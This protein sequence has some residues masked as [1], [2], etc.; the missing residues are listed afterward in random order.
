MDETVNYITGETREQLY[1]Y[2]I[3]S[4]NRTITDYIKQNREAE[5]ITWTVCPKCNQ[6]GADFAPGGYTYDKNG[7]RKKA[8]I[9][10]KCC[11]H[12]FVRD[13]G[14]LT[15]YSHSDASAW[16]KV[17]EDT[18]NRKSLASTAAEIDRH[19]VTVFHM[20][21]KFLSFIENHDEETVLRNTTEADEKYVHECH[22]GLVNAEIDHENRTITIK[23]E[24]KKQIDRGLGDDKSCIITA[25]ERN[26]QAYI[27]TENMGKISGKDAECLSDH[28]ADG[29]FVF[30]DGDTAYEDMLEKKNCPF[31]QLKSTLSYDSLNHMNNVNSLHSRMDEWLM[32]YRNVNT[33]YANRYNALFEIRHKY[34]GEDIQEIVIQIFRRLRGKVKYFFR[35]QQ[36]EQ[37]F[38]DAAAMSAREGRVGMAYINMLRSKRGYSVQLVF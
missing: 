3:D 29:T 31:M 8:L 4:L 14:Q 1:K 6:E 11:N 25:V 33:I 32:D 28:I 21:H 12:R 38:N 22:K 23:P 27:H 15:Y 26:G 35:R 7:N 37:I 9:K 10:C 17:V 18:V 30:T 20:R 5:T 36:Q 19:V 13:H 16:N 2:Q 34:A 24:P